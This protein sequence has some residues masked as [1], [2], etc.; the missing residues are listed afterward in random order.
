MVRLVMLGRYL[1]ALALGVPQV[2]NIR[3]EGNL[4]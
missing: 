1:M 2:E 4:F 3:E